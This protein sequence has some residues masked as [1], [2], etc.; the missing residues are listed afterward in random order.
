MLAMG[1]TAKPFESH[2]DAV[3]ALQAA[4]G[5]CAEGGGDGDEEKEGATEEE[6]QPH[7]VAYFMAK[8]LRW[9]K[10]LVRKPWLLPVAAMHLAAVTVQRAWSASWL[11]KTKPVATAA[12]AVAAT[13]GRDSS[14]QLPLKL[15]SM[16]SEMLQKAQ[17][18][19]NEAVAKALRQRYLDLLQRQYR[20]VRGLPGATASRQHVYPSFE[21]FCAALIQGWWCS[22]T[23]VRLVWRMVTYRKHKLYHVAAYEIQRIWRIE[24]QRTLVVAQEQRAQAQLDETRLV[25]KIHT[26]AS[27]VQRLW[28][29]FSDRRVFESLRDTIAVFRRTGDPYILLRHVQAREAMLLDPATQAHLRFRLGGS[30]FPP[31][32]YYKVYTHGNV[33][34]IC[35]FAPRNYAAERRGRIANYYERIENNG[36]RPLITRLPPSDG[37]PGGVR[38]FARDEVEAYT[39]RKVVRNF[40]FSRLRRRQ[41]MESRRR[42][43]TVEWMRKLYGMSAASSHTEPTQQLASPTGLS[44]QSLDANTPDMQRSAEAEEGQSYA[45]GLPSAR[46]GAARLSQSSARTPL[47]T[48]S[49][50]PPGTGTTSS[51]RGTASQSLSPSDARGFASLVPVPPPPRAL[52]A[53]GPAPRRQFFRAAGRPS[54]TGAPGGRLTTSPV[55]GGDSSAA[56]EGP[57]ENESEVDSL[58]DL[59]Q[60]ASA[61][62]E[63]GDEAL[64]DWSAKLDF[65][66]YM[67]N[68]QQL[69]TTGA[70]EGNLPMGLPP[71]TLLSAH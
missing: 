17:G 1:R 69:A 48:D 9:R 8:P 58:P 20:D 29:G 25:Q 10:N 40:H 67:E 12:A 32:I 53:Q 60:F 41:D 31:S 49:P 44:Q 16:R 38:N 2:A 66:A 51:P 35:S 3:A 33:V 43:R 42:Q 15:E 23:S 21:N 5:H 13:E 46:G 63:I 24:Y 52:G 27:K 57:A 6:E 56:T 54:S 47:G 26:A 11:R 37:K 14:R 68:W 62:M 28:R 18:E 7:G 65:E 59:P 70:T 19:Q 64:L 39:A 22:R 4:H 36:W 55:D 30:K 34:D 50:S 61:N 71:R 45:A